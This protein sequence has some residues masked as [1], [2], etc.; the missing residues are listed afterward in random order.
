MVQPAKE[1][2]GALPVGNERLGAM[3]FGNYDH[4]HIR[5]NEESLQAWAKIDK[6]RFKRILISL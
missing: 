5:L 3:V 2:G 4:Q 6:K 1:W